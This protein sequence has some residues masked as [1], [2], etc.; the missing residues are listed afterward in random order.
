MSKTK[1]QQPAYISRVHLKG[2]KS[3]RDLEIDF[4]AGLNIIIGPNGSGKT[5]FLEF[6]E[7]IIRRIILRNP[8][9]SEATFD[10]KG[11]DIV[12][13]KLKLTI[14]NDNTELSLPH[15]R[16]NVESEVY[17]N[18]EL[19]L[20]MSGVTSEFSAFNSEPIFE[21]IEGTRLK[22]Q[23]PFIE[24]LDFEN[25]LTKYFDN[26][27]DYYLVYR[28][29]ILS[30]WG[31]TSGYAINKYH[32]FSIGTLID[33]TIPRKLKSKAF[34]LKVKDT[35]IKNLKRFS[36]IENIEIDTTS[37]EETKISDSEIRIS[38]LNLLF[39]INGQKFRW[40]N[41]SDGTKRL[42]YIITSVLQQ[43]TQVIFLEEPELGIHP[44]QLFRL[45]DFLK[46][47]SETKQI[48]ITTHAPEALNILEKNE[49]D[50][51]VVTRYDTEKGTQMHHLSPKKTKKGQIYMVKVGHLSDF[52]VHSNLEEYEAEEY[53][54]E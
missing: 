4:K 11:N 8:F 40:V 52:W 3:I 42:F 29:N 44:D 12:T 9:E 49:L 30:G 50:R 33:T 37:A 27:N 54:V 34:T 14:N 15:M 22:D 39:T 43:N 32:T 23:T 51:I 7:M 38:N 47:Q 1:E 21:Q 31:G 25:P 13:N 45:M 53:E 24:K 5:N 46:E 35:L 41:L 36:P 20:K 18:G 28:N 16:F 2:Y 26:I 17:R 6:L 10:F 48:I 19:E